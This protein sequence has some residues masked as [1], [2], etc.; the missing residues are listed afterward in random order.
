MIRKEE[1]KMEEGGKGVYQGKKGGRKEENHVVEE[2]IMG[3]EGR[4]EQRMEGIKEDRGRKEG[5]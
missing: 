4:M 3:K 1:K 5:R 2:G